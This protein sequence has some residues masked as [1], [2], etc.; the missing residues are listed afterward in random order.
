MIVVS[1]AA[2]AAVNVVALGGVSRYVTA[3]S[4]RFA[5]RIAVACE[6]K[7]SVACGE[8]S[9]GVSAAAGLAAAGSSSTA[10]VSRSPIESLA[11]LASAL[12]R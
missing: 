8:V 6:R 5:W 11:A 4:A 9:S 2:I 7:F 3:S 12:M 1:V 10:T